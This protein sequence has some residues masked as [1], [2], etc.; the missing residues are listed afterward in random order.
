MK[1]KIVIITIFILILITLSLYYTYATDV[2]MDNTTGEV[3]LT[4]NIDIKDTSGRSITVKAGSTKTFDIFITNNNGGTINYGLA[5]SPTKE[6]GITIAQV[7]TSK[8]KVSELIENNT[9]HQ[10][11]LIIINNT[12]NDVTYSIIPITGYEKGGDLIVPDGYTLITDI[13]GYPIDKSGANFPK[14][15]NGLIPVVYDETKSSW[16][17]ADITSSTSTYGWYD[18]NNKKWANAVLVTNTNRSTY[19]SASNGTE[20]PEEEILAYYVW[21]PRYKYKVWNITKT[22][23]TDSYNART[24]G[25]D[26]IFERGTNSTGTIT[27]NDYSFAAPTADTPNQTCSGTNNE[28]YTHPAF[29]FGDTEV[30]GIWVGKF[31]LSSSNP[32]AEYGG[33]TSTTLTVRIKP[34]INSWRN[35][36]VSYYSAVIQNMQASSNE[37]GLTTDKTKADSHMLKNM[38]WGAVAY[39]TNS[40]YGRCSGGTCTEVAIN[41]YNSYKTGC[42]P[43]SAGSTSSGSTCN[44]YATELG[45][46]ASTTGNVYGI[47]DMS[48]GA[49]EYV[50]GN[51]SSGSGSYTYSAGSA[52]SNFTYSAETAK[53]LDT[54]AYGDSYT[55]PK[56]YN[57][58]RLGDATGENVLSTGGSGGWYNDYAYFVG[59][60]RPWFIR[61]GY[62][63]VGSYAGV[64][65]FYGNLGAAISDYSSRACLIPL[66]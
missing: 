40:N 3:D 61:G 63:N 41:S 24:T 46:T 44:A 1:K 31:E 14:L 32:T 45:Q 66:Q 26:I 60:S 28:Y 53:Y 64:F 21:I 20:I 30:E 19:Q 52:G 48:G 65:G 9:T 35:N 29:T 7:N 43:Q 37:Y 10:I 54:Y 56:A 13:Y 27:C 16:V 47:Y 25:I 18:Y 59:L 5:Y 8:N 42:G 12:S 62:Y 50:M 49:W 23:G 39:F 2:S 4:Y 17:K 11:S 55:D 34:S 58:A 51:S 33:G 22:Y 38:E 57:R 6:D 36:P 15:T